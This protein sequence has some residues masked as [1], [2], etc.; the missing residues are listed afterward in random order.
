MAFG[1]RRRI[2]VFKGRSGSNFRE[3]YQVAVD[4]LV[5]K[6]AVTEHNLAA[7]RPGLVQVPGQEDLPIL[8]EGSHRI[9]MLNWALVEEKVGTRTERECREHFYTMY[10]NGKRGHWTTDE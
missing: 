2:C 3:K 6:P 9:R 4:A 7:W 10:H 5:S 1:Q 8:K